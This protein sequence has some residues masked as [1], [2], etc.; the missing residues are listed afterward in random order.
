MSATECP[1]CHKF[2]ASVNRTTC[3]YCFGGL[4][5]QA[6]STADDIAVLTWR[7]LPPSREAPQ[8]N[9][10]PSPQPF[11]CPK[12]GSTNLVGDKKG[13]GL[14]KALVGGVLLGGVGLLGGFVGSKKVTVTC[15]QCGHAWEAGKQ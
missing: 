3:P 4:F 2:F 7:P 13:F 1:H 10:T 15:M 11:A 5:A 12:C 9:T 6:P 8:K 14:G